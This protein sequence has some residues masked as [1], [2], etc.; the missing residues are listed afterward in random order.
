VGED[1]SVLAHHIH[2]TV[3]N[4]AE[5]VAIRCVFIAIGVDVGLA[6]ADTDP[7]RLQGRFHNTI[8]REGSASQPTVSY[9]VW[10]D[11]A[12]VP[13]GT[14]DGRSQPTWLVAGI[15]LSRRVHLSATANQLPG[16]KLY[17][18]VQRLRR[19]LQHGIRVHTWYGRI[20]ELRLWA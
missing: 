8:P 5:Q 14:K 12:T 15:C 13:N 16:P 2:Q 19:L 20:R 4:D 1:R 10:P 18:T 3:D 17:G 9:L 11:S 7:R 6:S